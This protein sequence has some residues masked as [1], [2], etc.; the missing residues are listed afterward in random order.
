MLEG[1][2]ASNVA[3]PRETAAPPAQRGLLFISHANPQDN[4]AAAWFATQLT[5]L[6]YEVWC[7]L[8]N[9][10]AGESSFW[11][12]VQEKIE[13]E[14]A[15]FIFIL[16]DTSRDFRTK[17]G[18][19][20]E[21]QA[22]ANVKRDNFI[23][24][25]R[26]EKLTGSVPIL[27]GPDLYVD[28]E[29]W[30]H[31]LRELHKR[32]VK[33]GVPKSP[34]PADLSKVASWWPATVAE[35]ILLR[36]EPSKITSNVF[37]VAALPA[38]IHFLN[39]FSEGNQ[40][41]TREQMKGALPKSPTYAVQGE[42]AV[43]FASASD[44]KGAMHNYDAVDALVLP[45]SEFIEKGCA[46]FGVSSQ[47]A[48][49]ITTYLVADA[50]ETFLSAKGLSAKEL[51]YT[52]RKIWYPPKG[53]LRSDRSTFSEGGGR[54]LPVQFVGSVSHFK[55][56]FFWHFAVQPI[57]DLH[58]HFGILLSPKAIITAPYN[59]E[60]GQRPVPLDA[61]RVLKKLGWWN[62]E[63]RTKLAAFASWLADGNAK[64]LIPVGSQHIELDTA[65]EEMS[66]DVSYL[67]KD[68]DEVIKDILGTADA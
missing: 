23:I 53:L 21:V 49:N 16:S 67:D 54:K 39:I 27:I 40:L 58:T 59:R 57:V 66:F 20:K 36:A 52:R 8:R 50:F 44:L 60:E 45:T 1:S 5:L 14:A 12:K 17:A 15:K 34:T 56:T 41:K 11:L 28:S 22:A 51:S 38:N 24:P 3:S 46:K 10:E 19:Y 65:P 43:S 35:E 13:N 2:L 9:T 63:W 31:G 29:N 47:T 48:R 25:L 55:K 30:V 7:D 62:R 42:H 4:A 37:S 32:L 33:D 18:V 64:I 68:D 6:G 61:K 26:I